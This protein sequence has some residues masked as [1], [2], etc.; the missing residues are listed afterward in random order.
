MPCLW[1]FLGEDGIHGVEKLPRVDRS[2]GCL[3]L[4]PPSLLSFAPLCF[5]PFVYFSFS[6]SLSTLPSVSSLLIFYSIFLVM[7]VGAI[8]KPYEAAAI[9]GMVSQHENM[10]VSPAL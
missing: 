7:L 8:V 1:F 10:T 6:L 4:Q 9:Q 2:Q 3:C 5:F